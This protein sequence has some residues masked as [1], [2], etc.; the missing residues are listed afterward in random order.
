MYHCC[1][2][3]SGGQIE[4][5]MVKEITPREEAPNGPETPAVIEQSLQG[6]GKGAEGPGALYEKEIPHT[7]QRHHQDKTGNL[8]Q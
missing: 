4:N 1:P 6:A 2:H 7:G 5:F 8:G 3:H